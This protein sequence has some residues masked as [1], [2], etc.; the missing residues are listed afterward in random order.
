MECLCEPVVPICVNNCIF[1][2]FD[3]IVLEET[4]PESRLESTTPP[5]HP[6]AAQD[7]SYAP[8]PTHYL[9]RNIRTVHRERD[10]DC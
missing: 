5:T 6:L 1:V 8:S 3:V 4:L 9:N 10:L 2:I 7:F